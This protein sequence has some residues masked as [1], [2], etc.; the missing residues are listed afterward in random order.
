MGDDRPHGVIRKPNR[1]FLDPYPTHI[2]LLLQDSALLG[3]QAGEPVMPA[4]HLD[5]HHKVALKEGRGD[6]GYLE[7]RLGP[8][9]W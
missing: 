5:R 9:R 6:R 4:C 7:R 8:A 1:D 2:L 3:V